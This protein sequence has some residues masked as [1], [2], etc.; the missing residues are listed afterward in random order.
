M[1]HCKEQEGFISV[2]HYIFRSTTALVT[3]ACR[4]DCFEYRLRIG[5]FLFFSFARIKLDEKSSA[6][7]FHI[8]LSPETD[9]NTYQ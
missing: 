9:K 7:L 2:Q 1:Y 3:I 4:K 8:R 5:H 6:F